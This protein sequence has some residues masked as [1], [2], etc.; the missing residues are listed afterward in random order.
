MDIDILTVMCYNNKDD[1]N[2][3]DAMDH[4]I[5]SVLGCSVQKYSYDLPTNMPQYLVNDYSYRKYGIENIE[6]L[7]VTPYEFSIAA[8]K[9]Q[10]P[11]MKQITNLPIVL[12]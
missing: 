7:F 11:K 6:C 1:G 4:Y 3:E 8:Y 12:Q 9:K 10:Y 5:K 2:K